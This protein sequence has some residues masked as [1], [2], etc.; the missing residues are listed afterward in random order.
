[1]TPHDRREPPS[2]EAGYKFETGYCATHCS[3]GAGRGLGDLL[4]VAA[5]HNAETCAPSCFDAV[6]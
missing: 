4:V 1:M 5:S 6:S 3:G 2:R